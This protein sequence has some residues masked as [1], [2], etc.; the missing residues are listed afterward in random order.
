MNGREFERVRAIEMKVYR[1]MAQF[2]ARGEEIPELLKGRYAM[3]VELV[4]ALEA[5]KGRKKSTE[6]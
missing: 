2:Q 3:M 4:E 1:G 5:P 6:K